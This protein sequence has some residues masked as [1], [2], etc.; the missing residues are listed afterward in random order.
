MIWRMSAVG[1]ALALL[2]G[3]GGSAQP[4]KSPADPVAHTESQLE[5]AL[6]SLAELPEAKSINLECPGDDECD[7]T[8]DATEWS[9]QFELEPVGTGAAAEAAA[10]QVIADFGFLIITQFTDT[11]AAAEMAENRKDRQAFDGP[12]DNEPAP[13]SA[14]GEKGS[15]TLADTVVSGWRGFASSRTF[16]LVD[17]DGT[18]N[19]GRHES[20]VQVRQGSVVVAAFCGAGTAGRS[21][22]ECDKLARTYVDGYLSRLAQQVDADR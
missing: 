22:V 4:E 19:S 12:F 20:L 13:G 2:S 15:G 18:V 3:C 11:A 17:R 1:L 16:D 7:G 9:V 6:P 10:N 14:F 21:L 8:D 5:A